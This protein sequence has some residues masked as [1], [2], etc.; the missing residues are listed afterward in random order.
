MADGKS[1]VKLATQ[2]QSRGLEI[3]W[4]ERRLYQA[5]KVG[6]CTAAIGGAGAM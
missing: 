5:A 1:H 3:R 2:D 6:A 4:S